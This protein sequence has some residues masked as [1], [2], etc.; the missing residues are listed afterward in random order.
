[1]RSKSRNSYLNFDQSRLVET[2]ERF[3]RLLVLCLFFV[4]GQSVPTALAIASSNSQS[5]TVICTGSGL[6]LV[7]TDGQEKDDQQNDSTGCTCSLAPHSK[8]ILT[9][10]DSKLDVPEIAVSIVFDQAKLFS[11]K[12][13]SSG[14]TGC[15]G[16]PQLTRSKYSFSDPPDV[17]KSVTN[18]YL[19]SFCL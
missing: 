14:E 13:I 4:L 12:R 2:V 5:W 18:R 11:P 10:A 6:K 9:V 8:A 16:P 1:M 3:L 17:T 7:Q 19:R 15:R